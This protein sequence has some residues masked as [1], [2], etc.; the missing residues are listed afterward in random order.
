M[1]SGHETRFRGYLGDACSVK[2]VDGEIMEMYTKGL[3]CI[4][5]EKERVMEMVKHST[6]M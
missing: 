3:L 1:I 6:L 5:R 2:R 4:V